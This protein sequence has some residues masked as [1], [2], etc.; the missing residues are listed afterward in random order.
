MTTAPP[1]LRVEHASR[2]FGGLLA[3]DAVDLAVPE[4]ELH[5]IIGPNGAGKTTLFNL[6]AGAFP[7]SGGRVLLAGRDITRL[8]PERRCA[9]GLARTFQ[10]PRPFAGLDVLDNVA[11]GSLDHSRSV[12][13][14]REA[15][16]AVL[17]TTGLA[18]H[19][20][21][22]AGALPVGLRKRL[23]LARALATKPRRLLLDEVLGGLHGAEI[24]Q[25]IET[26]RGINASGVTVVMIE[27]VLPAVMSLAERVTVLDQGRIIAAGTPAEVTRDPAVIAAYLGDELAA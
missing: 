6:I 11:V 9:L 2:R 26:I 27:H 23:E 13:A 21:A 10:I 8:P 4:G 22:P 3:V 16:A 18:A 15:A 24:E 7:P 20:A 1:L 17:A 5:G 14:A 25:M 19:A 12:A